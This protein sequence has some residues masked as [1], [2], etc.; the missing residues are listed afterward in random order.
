MMAAMV[1]GP[2]QWPK[3]DVVLANILKLP[4]RAVLLRLYRTVVEKS[5]FFLFTGYLANI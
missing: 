5:Y 1:N 2:L 3:F 4:F